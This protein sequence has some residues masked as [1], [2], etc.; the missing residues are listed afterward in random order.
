LPVWRALFGNMTDALVKKTVLRRTQLDGVPH[1][2]YLAAGKVL[3]VHAV[4]KGEF[5]GVSDLF[6]IPSRSLSA[7][8]V[9]ALELAPEI[10]RQHLCTALGI[11]NGGAAWCAGDDILQLGWLAAGDEQLYV[12]YAL[13]AHSC[14]AAERLRIRA[15]GGHTV[16]LV[17]ANRSIQGQGAT[18]ALDNPVPSRE[19]VIREGV[20]A[21]G[22]ADRLAA[23][24]RAP[25]AAELV[26]DKRLKKV[27]V[28]GIEVPLT[29]D[30][31]A[32]LF[33]EI[34]ASSNGTAVTAEAITKA[35]SAARLNTDGTTTARQAKGKAKK[36]IEDVLAASGAGDQDD[37]FP[38]CG[39]GSYRCVLR[40]FVG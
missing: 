5:H 29:P 40:A 9:E 33:I 12:A 34:L 21:C 36:A 13:R 26:V 4:G 7:T 18:V 31:Q 24:Y 17:P 35:L 15:A 37:P 38:S 10:F 16:L 20:F 25:A 23:I 27:W 11:T 28:R 32:Y 19:Q 14:E 1:P 6:E 3:R 2:D 22:I 8:D 39:T 30:S